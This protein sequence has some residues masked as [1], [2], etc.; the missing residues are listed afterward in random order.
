MIFSSCAKDAGKQLKLV[1]ARLLQV[2]IRN[3]RRID[4]RLEF[5]LNIVITEGVGLKPAGQVTRGLFWELVL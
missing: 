5:F 2:N 3:K 4:R 1:R